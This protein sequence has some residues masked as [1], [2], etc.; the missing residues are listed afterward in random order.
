MEQT[1]DK[2]DKTELLRAFSNQMAD[3]VERVSPSIV[4]VN[5]R[6][7]QPGSG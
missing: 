5:G 7:R 1:T 6:Q 4:L 2:I 3:A